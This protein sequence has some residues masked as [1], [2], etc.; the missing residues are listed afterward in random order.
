MLAGI[1]PDTGEQVDAW[2]PASEFDGETETIDIDMPDDAAG[3][4]VRVTLEIHFLFFKA[5]A[6]GAHTL[7]PWTESFSAT[8]CCR[9]CWFHSKCPC[10]YLPLGSRELAEVEQVACSRTPRETV[11]CKGKGE[12]GGLAL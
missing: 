7:G 8:H 6:L 1:D 11:E 4:V 9:D 3:G 5:D 12:R 2:S 10:A